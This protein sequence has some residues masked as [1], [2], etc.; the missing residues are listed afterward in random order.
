LSD[1]SLPIRQEAKMD[2]HL[3]Q[4]AA[5]DVISLDARYTGS[6]RSKAVAPASPTEITA[7]ALRPVLDRLLVAQ[8]ELCGLDPHPTRAALSEM[9]FRQARE[10]LGVSIAL[11]RNLST[12][13]TDAAP[14][15][16][17]LPP[18]DNEMREV[19]AAD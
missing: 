2:D 13:S 1:F 11:L 5:C 18:R 19:R 15:T 16:A 14:A 17:S 6:P 7:E 8:F 4:G 10:A 12:A 9:R 3:S